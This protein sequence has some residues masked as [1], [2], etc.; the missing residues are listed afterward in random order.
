METDNTKHGKNGYI[1]FYND[2]TV[3]VWADTSFDAQKEAQRKLKVSE[4]NRYKITVCLCE[5]EGEQVI[6]DTTSI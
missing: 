3:E 4:K 1:A 5:K 2:K 6:H